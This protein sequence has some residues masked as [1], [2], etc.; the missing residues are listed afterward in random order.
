[1]Q[2]SVQSAN[3][4]GRLLAGA[5]GYRV[6]TQEGVVV[7]ALERIRYQTQVSHPDAIVV[8]RGRLFRRRPCTFPFES[9]YAVSVREGKVVLRPD[10]T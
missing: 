3:E 6:I 7:G 8:S 2:V 4:L 1:M 10:V 9:I 5:Q